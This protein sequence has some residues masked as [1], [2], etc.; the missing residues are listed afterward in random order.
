MRKNN[1]ININKIN[2]SEDNLSELLR[3]S[4]EL[5]AELEEINLWERVSNKIDSEYHKELF[6]ESLANSPEI[7]IQEKFIIGLSEYIDN[8]CSPEKANII[9]EHLL[10]CSSCREYYLSLIKQK[11]ALT[12]SFKELEKNS[13]LIQELDKNQDILWNKIQAKLFPE[14][15]EKLNNL[16]TKSA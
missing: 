7:S 11:K 5:P 1:K 4:F 13:D 12:Y 3:K 16:N 15:I 8:E 9:T 6:S 14:D 10:E 2:T